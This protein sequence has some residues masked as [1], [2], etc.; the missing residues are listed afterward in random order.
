MTD[1]DEGP[2][3][4]ELQLLSS[5]KVVQLN[6]LYQNFRSEFNRLRKKNLVHFNLFTFYEM[7][8]VSVL[9]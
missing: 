5:W 7:A 4:M 1:A 9:S 2:G 6:A 3:L 8:S